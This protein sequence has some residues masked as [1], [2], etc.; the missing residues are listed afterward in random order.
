MDEVVVRLD[1]AVEAFDIAKVHQE[2]W[3]SQSELDQRQQAVATGEELRLAFPVLEDPERLVQAARTD[4]VE[5]AGNHRAGP[6]SSSAR[7]GCDRP[8]L[9]GWA[10]SDWRRSRGSRSGRLL[11]PWPRLRCLYGLRASIGLGS[12]ARQRESRPAGRVGRSDT[13]PIDSY[14]GWAWADAGP[15]GRG[16]VPRAPGARF[17][18]G[19]H[20]QSRR[21]G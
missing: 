14:D 1:D 11:K 4:I 8:I 10:S 5:L 2:R 19:A 3:L 7:A 12:F 6:S 21:S 18:Y 15:R 13:T 16:L 17:A 9:P 20:N